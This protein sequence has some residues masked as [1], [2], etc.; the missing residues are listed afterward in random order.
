[1]GQH[2]YSEINLHIVWHAKNN[3]PLLTPDVEQA[4]HASIRARCLATDRVVFHEVG[5]T[6]THVHLAV[7]IPPTL[8]ISEFIGRLKG[9]CSHEVN[10][11]LGDKCLQWQTGYG[12]VTFG[13]RDL[14][15]VKQ[16]I[17]NQ[18]EHHA[19]QRVYDRLERAEEREGEVEEEEGTAA[20]QGPE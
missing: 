7:S 18:K 13:T 14:D 12:V 8:L 19:E 9:G 15:W 6:E 10:Q 2:M 1:M 11:A 3:A 4:A 16:Y 17:V 20:A 5:G